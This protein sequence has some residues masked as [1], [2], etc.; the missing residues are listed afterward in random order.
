MMNY[1]IVSQ[2]IE[3]LYIKYSAWKCL[4]N[5]KVLMKLNYSK[6]FTKF[7]QLNKKSSYPSTTKVYG[8][9]SYSWI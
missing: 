5:T 3:C 8:C 1:L 6:N 9:Y 2:I 7:S 4:G